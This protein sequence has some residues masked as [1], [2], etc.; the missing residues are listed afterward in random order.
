MK[1]KMINKIYVECECGARI[2]G[3]SKKHA[4]SILQAHLRSKKHKE[5]MEIKERR[6]GKKDTLNTKTELGGRK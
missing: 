2:K 5:L 3:I 4:E 1:I 6:E